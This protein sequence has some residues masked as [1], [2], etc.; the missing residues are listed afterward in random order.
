MA[1]GVIGGGRAEVIAAYTVALSDPD[2]ARAD[3]ILAAAAPG[4]RVDQ[5]ARKAAALEMKLDPEAART[6]KE[7]ARNTRQRVEVRRELS[8]NASLSG[9]E[10]DPAKPWRPRPTSMPSRSS[11]ATTAA[12]TAP[13]RRSGPA[14]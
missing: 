11:S 7:H 5:L 8:G 9:R 4:L 12:W 10:L 1:A 6:R 14:S 13:C 3:D 2:A